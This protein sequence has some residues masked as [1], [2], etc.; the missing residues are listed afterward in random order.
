MN[1]F[2]PVPEYSIK[3]VSNFFK[4]LRRYSQSNQASSCGK[5][6]GWDAI[7]KRVILAPLSFWEMLC[8]TSLFKTK[9]VWGRG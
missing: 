1:Q 9:A 5:E 3:T 6:V 7:S 4:N 2:A 8:P